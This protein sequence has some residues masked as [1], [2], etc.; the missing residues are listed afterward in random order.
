[1]ISCKRFQAPP[2]EWTL[3]TNAYSAKTLMYV[4]PFLG[5]CSTLPSP[6][7]LHYQRRAEQADPGTSPDT[8][9]WSTQLCRVLRELTMLVTS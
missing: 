2:L 9:L 3:K 1:M 8:A 4:E 6:K 7:G 5:L